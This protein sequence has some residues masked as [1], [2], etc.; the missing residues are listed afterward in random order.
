LL[1][2]NELII[3]ALLSP[4]FRAIVQGMTKPKTQRKTLHHHAKRILLLTPKFVHGMVLG[5]IVGVIVVVGLRATVAS[6]LSLSSPRDCDTNAVIN[7]GALTTTELQQRYSN[8]GVSTIYG[9][10]GITAADVSGMSK[11]AVAGQVYK[12]G[13][14]SVNGVTVATQAITAG[15]EN[16]SGSTKVSLGGVTFYKRPPSVSFVPNSIAAYVVMDKGLFKYAILGACGNPVIA[17]AVPKTAPPIPTPTPTP[18]PPVVTTITPPST[19]TPPSTPTPPVVTTASAPVSQLPNTGPGAVVIIAVLSVI[20]GY[21][22]HATHRHIRHKRRLHHS[23]M[24]HHP[25]AS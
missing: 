4:G 19:Q 18:T 24:S 15:R 6:A 11:T 14:V 21:I 10:F 22:F 17:T 8:A 3:S 12:N 5:A 1:S 25:H 13:T 20:G 2:V 23:N 16:I 7:C 9:Y